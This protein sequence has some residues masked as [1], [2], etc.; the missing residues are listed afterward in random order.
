MRW[1]TV[2]RQRSPR[3]E[4]SASSPCSWGREGSI[5]T[6]VATTAT[7]L[8]MGSLDDSFDLPPGVVATASGA[9]EA[10]TAAR[11][12]PDI[13]SIDTDG[14]LR[15]EHHICLRWVRGC[16][17][18]GARCSLRHKLPTLADENRLVHSADGLTKD[19]F[20]RPRGERQER[21]TTDPLQCQTVCVSGLP[22]SGQQERRSQLD[23]LGSEWGEVVRTWAVADPHTG[24]VR[25]R[26]RSSA[27]VFVE[28]MHGKP[29][30]PD[31]PET[32][33]ELSWC[34][35]D[36]A[37]IQATQGREMALAAAA[38]ARA[39]R[40]ST[41]ELYARLERERCPQ[42]PSDAM[43]A[44]RVGGWGA[45]AVAKRRRTEPSEGGVASSDAAA[46]LEQE[47]HALSAVAAAYPG[48]EHDSP[49]DEAPASES[50]ATQDSACEPPIGPVIS[51]DWVH[52]VDPASGCT[53]YYN[54][55]TAQSQ[56][57]RPG[58]G[59]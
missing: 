47:E 27:Q 14:E 38:E 15:G 12:W 50:H 55:K 28:A 46:W 25:F 18:L 23:A 51:A 49:R 21:S 8:V 44:T 34:F 1:V 36:P 16:C 59:G 2:T 4:S 11:C 17:T 7:T 6:L 45:A 57:Q 41:A 13:D 20:G 52:G 19:I 37:A 48:G 40:E 3:A 24:Y 56:W 42:R 53:Y 29:L 54:L 35:H 31:E 5:G 43:A 32:L 10:S 58:S 33:L 39:R 22:A 30:R 9:V 26:W